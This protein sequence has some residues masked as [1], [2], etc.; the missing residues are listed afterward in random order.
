VMLASHSSSGGTSASRSN[1]V[2]VSA[3]YLTGT[4]SIFAACFKPDNRFYRVWKEGFIEHVY[5][6]KYMIHQY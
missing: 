2:R 4:R 6:D 1:S 5:D 3:G